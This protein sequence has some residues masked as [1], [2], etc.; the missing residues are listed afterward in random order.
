MPDGLAQETERGCPVN[1]CD[2]C[3]HHGAER[4]GFC[5]VTGAVAWHDAPGCEHLAVRPAPGSSGLSELLADCKYALVNEDLSKATFQRQ[6]DRAALIQ[7]IKATMLWLEKDH[8]G[9]LTVAA[10]SVLDN[11]V[12]SEARPGAGQRAIAALARAVK[13]AE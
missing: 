3:A 10:R 7:R 2:E 11:C 13:A 5:G 8:V 6:A 9:A 1:T 4:Q 12:P